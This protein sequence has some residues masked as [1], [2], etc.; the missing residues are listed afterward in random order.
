MHKPL[1]NPL[2]S[3]A[4]AVGTAASCHTCRAGCGLSL[5]PWGCGVGGLS[6]KNHKTRAPIMASC[7]RLAYVAAMRSLRVTIVQGFQDLMD[8]EPNVIIWQSHTQ[9]SVWDFGMGIQ[10][11]A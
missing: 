5:D 9:L 10:A 1:Q 8:V 3:L 11:S 6:K 2:F 4:V 7:Y